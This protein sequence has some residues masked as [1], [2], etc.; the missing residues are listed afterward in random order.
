MTRLLILVE[1]DSEEL[2]VKNILSPHL[3]RFGVYAVATGVVSKRLASGK[4]FTGG[5]SW[6]NVRKSLQPLLANSDSWVITLL[7]FYGLPEDFPGVPDLATLP[8]NAKSRT[9]YVQNQL[10]AAVGSPQRFIPFLVLHEFE[11]WYFSSP[12]QVAEYYGKPPVAALMKQTCCEFGGPENINHGKET[13]P[14]KRLEGYGIGFRKT[15]GVAILKEIGL[16]SIRAACQNFNKWLI[17]FEKTGKRYI[18]IYEY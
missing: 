14:S 3:A 12:E 11:T 2:F 6:L 8:I 15:S 7:D 9:E 17:Q 18:D 10:S 4:K 1:G 13:H 16:E 5:N